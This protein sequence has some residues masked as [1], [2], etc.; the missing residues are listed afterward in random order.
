VN[1]HSAKVCNQASIVRLI[2]VACLFLQSVSRAQA[3]PNYTISTVAGTG[4][5]QGYSGDGGAATSADFNGPFDVVLDSSGNFYVSDSGNFRV[6]KVSGG[7]ISTIAGNGTQGYSGNNGSPTSAEL[8]SPAGLTFDSSGNLYIADGGNYVVWKITGGTIAVVA[9]SNSAGAGFSGDLGPATSAQLSTPSGVVLD[10]SGNLYVADSGNSVVREVCAKTCP[11]WGGTAGEINTYAG[12]FSAGPGYAGD[13]GQADRAE[14]QNPNGLAI[15]SAG[16]LYIADSDN[17]VIRKV[18]ASTGII[19]TVAGNGSPTSPFNPLGDGGPATVASLDE[20]KGV[21]VD[22]DGYIYIA[23]TDNCLIRVVEPNSIITTIAGNSD[24]G[25]GFSGDG[26]QAKAATLT[27]PSGLAISGGKIYIADDGN[28]VI[29]LLTP[30]AVAPVVPKINAGGVVSASDFGAF[31]SVAPGSWI[32]IYGT[33]LAGTTGQWA[34][35]NFNGANAPTNLDGV[36]VTVGG[37]PAFIDFVSPTQVNVE[38]PSG[39][40]AGPQPLILSTASGT[41]SAY[42]V[43]VNATEPGFWAPPNFKIGGKQYLGAQ[44][45]DFKSYILPTG[46]VSGLTSE[47]ASPGDTII[48]YG[49]GFGTVTPS[50]PAGQIVSGQTALTSKLEISFGGVPATLSYAGLAPNYVGLYQF[51]VVVPTVPAG[52]AVPVT[53][54]LGGVSGTQT[55]YTAIGN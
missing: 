3:P 31:S 47:P 30:I 11:A 23:D 15:D 46:A 52:S 50:T 4:A 13:G 17:H 37:Q 7:N 36:T 38:V 26:G 48:L 29:R 42:S 44:S 43:T 33:N 6:R 21:A 18:T 12:Y 16:N 41:S 27:F 28:Q 32:E 24:L 40:T 20:P 25:C 35:S 49:V 14:L 54:T 55:L 9:G 19:T 1:R 2:A 39:V 53:F 8:N 10:S 45:S 5:T 34:S 22:S 51:D